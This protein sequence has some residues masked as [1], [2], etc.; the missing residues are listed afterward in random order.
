MEFVGDQAKI[1]FEDSTRTELVSVDS[2][3][4]PLQAGDIILL[5][6]Q[7]TDSE[8]EFLNQDNDNTSFPIERLTRDMEVSLLHNQEQDQDHNKVFFAVVV[9]GVDGDNDGDGDSDGMLQIKTVKN[10][11]ILYRKI[12][13]K[14]IIDIQ[15]QPIIF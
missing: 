6:I 5:Q 9:K 11:F 15:D 12:H 13:P 3:K 1:Y 2:I 10:G 4:P 7:F 8:L 14:D